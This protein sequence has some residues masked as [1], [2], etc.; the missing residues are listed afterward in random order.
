MNRRGRLA[1]TIAALAFPGMA[2]AATATPP[3]GRERDQC[4]GSCYARCATQYACQPDAS[5]NCFTH[6]NQCKAVCRSNCLR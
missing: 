2:L 6:F 1:I 3:N 5:R 4:Y